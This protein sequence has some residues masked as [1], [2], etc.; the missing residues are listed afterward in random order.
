VGGVGYG[1]LDRGGGGYTYLWVFEPS[2]FLR[3]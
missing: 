1:N 3:P 2:G